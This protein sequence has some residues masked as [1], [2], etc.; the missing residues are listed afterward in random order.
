MHVKKL[1]WLLCAFSFSLKA[2]EHEI[3]ALQP[4]AQAPDFSLPA[5]DG[6]TYSLSDFQQYPVLIILFTCNHCPTA[7]AYEDKIIKLVDDY[8]S[9]GVRLVAVSPND[10]DAVSLSELGY[11]D[12]GDNMDDMKIR[13]Q[14]KGFSFPYLFDGET[15]ATSMAYGPMATPHAFVFDEKRILRYSGRIDDTEDPYVVPAMNDLR[16]AIDAIL[17]GNKV[18]VPVTKT[19]GCSIKWSWK[20][21]WVAK[22][23]EEWANEPITL[24]EISV[25]GIKTLLSN[26]TGKL[27]LINVWA[28]W[29]GP[30]MMELPSFVDINRMYRDRD[31]ELVMISTDKIS[32]KDKVL[33]KLRKIEAS[34]SQYIYSGSKIYDLIEAVDPAWSGALPYTLLIEPGGKVHRRIAG[35][36]DPLR[37]KKEVVNYLGRYYADNK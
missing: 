23:K 2:Q 10:P 27:L 15:Q 19:F 21:D 33:E 26:P 20:K 9:R 36:I 37:M 12:V 3:K 4:G 1:L 11:S 24:D 25:E 32:Q 31:F 22:Q 34:N 14:E 17:S 13:A 29:C 7:Q 18:D 16:N 5:T 30:C 6:K 35:P 28:T 8:E